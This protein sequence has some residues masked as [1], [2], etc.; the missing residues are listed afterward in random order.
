M[1]GGK[2][3]KVGVL[4]VEVS[5]NKEVGGVVVNL[6]KEVGIRGVVLVRAV[7]GGDSEGGIIGG[8]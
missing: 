3:A 2:I 5:K 6:L 1:V 7:N 4:G 8:S